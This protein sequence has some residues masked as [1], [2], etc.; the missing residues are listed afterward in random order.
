M[1]IENKNFLTQEEKNVLGIMLEEN[2]PFYWHKEQ[3]VNDN[4]PFLG[5]TLW[6]RNSNLPCSN[7]CDF[8]ENIVKKFCIKNNI[9]F[10]KILRGSVNLSFPLNEK[11]CSPASIHQDYPFDH[12]QMLIYLNDSD[13]DTIIFNKEGKEIVKKITP[14]KFK[15]ICFDNVPHIG[16]GP[17]ESN[18]RVVIVICFN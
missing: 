8:I 17:I 15:I 11:N 12:K 16:K 3:I 9:E 7:F 5:H 13:G 2:F 14:E 10:K 18:R 1:Y 4:R 6:D